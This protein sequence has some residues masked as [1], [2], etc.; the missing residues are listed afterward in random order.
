M[1]MLDFNPK[2]KSIG[3]CPV[4]KV[5]FNMEDRFWAE[6]GRAITSVTI[7]HH[8]HGTLMRMNTYIADNSIWVVKE[9]AA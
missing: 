8:E 3:Q 6:H 5:V 4:E 2:W 1:T 7:Y 9:R